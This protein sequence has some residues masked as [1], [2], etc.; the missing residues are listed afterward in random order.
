MDEPAVTGHGRLAREWQTRAMTGSSPL[1]PIVES[2]ISDVLRL[3]A[4]HVELLSHLDEARLRQLLEWTASAEI[5]ECDGRTAGFVLVFGPGQAYDSPNYRWFASTYGTSF[6][7][8][9]R[10]VVDDAFR[11]RGLATAA[12]EVLES[13]AERFGRLTL[14]VNVEP[15]NEPSLAFHRNRG[16]HE[17]TRL[18]GPEHQVGLMTKELS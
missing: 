7:Y 12:Y 16:Y 2:D 8:L 9:D 1:R 17:V 18:G 3:N 15:A 11:R 4:Q 14:E 6:A 5:I 13:R 10:I